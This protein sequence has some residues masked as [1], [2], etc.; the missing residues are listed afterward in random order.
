[1]QDENTEVVETPVEETAVGTTETPAAEPAVEADPIA[2]AAAAGEA[3]AEA[4]E[5][6]ESD[7]SEVEQHK[8]L[9][10]FKAGFFN[11]ETKQL[12]QKEYEIDP[13]FH[14][15]MKDEASEKLVR[16]LHEKAFG[17][18]SVKERFELTRQEAAEVRAENRQIQG[19]ISQLR[20]TYQT[21]VKTGNWHKMDSFFATLQMPQE[22]ILQYALAKMQLAEMDPAQRN[23][24]MGQL[25]AEQ[26]A[27]RLTQQQ[28]DLQEQSANQQR[29]NLT[30][31]LQHTL[32][33]AEVAPLV[34][35]FDERVGKP[36]AFEN[37]VRRE[38]EFEFQRSGTT[39]Q[40]GQ[41]VQRVIDNLGLAKGATGAPAAQPAPQAQPA[42]PGNTTT[43]VK[44]TANVIPNVQGRSTSPLASKPKSID[45]ILKHR[46]EVH[47]F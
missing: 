7:E 46:K 6:D 34:K 18:D 3:E 16:E 9:L 24:I 21:A 36:G 4:E 25:T 12:E 33:R 10:K 39:L 37:L 5:T 17:L 41:A 26:Q 45:D 30:V 13:K 23:A 38:G 22:H 15:I 27:E 8:P 40:P 20:N 35:A 19:T 43:I 31:L 2:T 47:G 28:A 1:M 44:R 11:K 42:A 29:E 32:D 14:G